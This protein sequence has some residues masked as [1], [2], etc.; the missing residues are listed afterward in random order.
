MSGD[1]A[2]IDAHR[3]RFLAFGNAR[4][5]RDDPRKIKGLAECYR[6]CCGPAVSGPAM[7]SCW[8][9]IFFA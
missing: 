3:G 8:Q 4:G 1:R 2:P 6:G 9:E 5:R 7:M